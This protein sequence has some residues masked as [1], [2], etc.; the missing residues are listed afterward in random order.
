MKFSNDGRV[1]YCK[2]CEM[3]LNDGQDVNHDIG[4][5]HK[6]RRKR[7]LV[8]ISDRPKVDVANISYVYATYTIHISDSF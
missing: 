6:K 8:Y 4:K 5:K 1:I 3:W 2:L 7:K